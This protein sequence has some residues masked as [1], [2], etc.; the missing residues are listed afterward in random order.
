MRNLLVI[1][2]LAFVGHSYAKFVPQYKGVY[3]PI[4]DISLGNY[5][6]EHFEI[7]GGAN[8]LIIIPGG[9][10]KPLCTHQSQ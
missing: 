9:H 5:V 6:N 1:L 4:V 3:G 2:L 7:G 10:T 8:A